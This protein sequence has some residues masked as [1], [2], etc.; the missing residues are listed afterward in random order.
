MTRLAL[1][2]LAALLL[3]GT[4][5]AEPMKGTYE[6]RCQD[7]KTR[8]W[9]VAGRVSDPEIVDRAG[10]GREARGKGPDGKPVAVPMPA[11]RT[12]MV[13]GAG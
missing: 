5:A 4:A 13:S 9:T 3:A 8:Q 6:V 7:P 1:P 12:C 11:D 2:I 10:G